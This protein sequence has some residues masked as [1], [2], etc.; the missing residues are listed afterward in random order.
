MSGEVLQDA[1]WVTIPT[2]LPVSA[3]IDFCRDVERLLRINSMYEFEDWHETG[4]DSYAMKIHNLRTGQTL[5]VPF[6]V[7]RHD[8]GVALIYG[9]GLKARTRFKV[10]PGPQ[11]ANLIV[12]DDYSGTP[13]AEREVRAA[14][15]DK[16]LVYWGNDL[17]RYL[18]QWRRWSAFKAWRWYMA[19]V[20]QP[21][22]PRARRVAFMVIVITALEFVAFL[23]VFLI[24]AM[25]WQQHIRLW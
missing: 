24:F 1:A 11:G 25:E 10:E 9:A 6:S 16:S 3:A 4:P 20:W 12:T 17:H 15:I 8:D 23:A 18:E 5:E 22:K 7:G 2:R 13:V 14:E 21:M 19:R